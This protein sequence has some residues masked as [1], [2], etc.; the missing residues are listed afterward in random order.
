MLFITYT[1]L[2]VL[3]NFAKFRKIGDNSS[4]RM[5]SRLH[6]PLNLSA[7]SQVPTSIFSGVDH[8]NELKNGLE[9]IKNLMMPVSEKVYISTKDKPVSC[10]FCNSRYFWN[11]HVG[12]TLCTKRCML[13]NQ[14]TPVL[15]GCSCIT[16]ELL[17]FR[18]KFLHWFWGKF[19]LLS[20]WIV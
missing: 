2:K 1:V 4:S 8:G 11:G 6:E 15:P 20:L 9:F 16:L 18:S 14:D 3:P 12:A 7:P 5:K 17:P 10:D 13:G 19:F